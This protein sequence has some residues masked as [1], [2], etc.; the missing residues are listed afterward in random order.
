MWTL[1]NMQVYI[2]NLG[3]YN[4]GEV[5]EDW[6]TPPIDMENIK[7]HIDSNGK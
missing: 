4:D 5:I 1:M 7:E 2:A 3:K 6:F